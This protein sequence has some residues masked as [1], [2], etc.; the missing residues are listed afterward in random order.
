MQL[1]SAIIF[2]LD[3]SH[4]FPPQTL[5]PQN[6]TLHSP[7]SCSSITRSIKLDL[8]LNIKKHL[9]CMASECLACQLLNF[10]SLGSNWLIQS[11][12]S[13]AHKR[14]CDPTAPLNSILGARVITVLSQLGA[15]FPKVSKLWTT[16]QHHF[17]NL[18]NGNS[19]NVNLSERFYGMWRWSFVGWNMHKRTADLLISYTNFY[20][21][22]I[23]GLWSNLC[24][25]KLNIN[26]TIMILSLLSQKLQYILNH[27]SFKMAT[28]ILKET[29]FI[30]TLFDFRI[31][32][33]WVQ[34]FV[35]Y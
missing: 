10:S 7:Q 8:L 26:S 12:I 13:K 6:E 22:L 33:R 29:W 20:H 15:P 34:E 17:L 19:A 5:W 28:T 32:W 18:W 2:G 31:F 24:R 27:L 30:I 23:P 3:T 35:K 9:E 16:S 11:F 4:Q 1:F 14:I 21:V 25:A